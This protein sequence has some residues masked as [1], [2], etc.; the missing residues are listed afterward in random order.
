VIQPPGPGRAEVLVPFVAEIVPEVNVAA[1]RLII[2][3]PPGLL[4][5]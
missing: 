5:P 2:D 3:P 1:G 4:E